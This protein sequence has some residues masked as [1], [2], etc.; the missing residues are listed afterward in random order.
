MRDATAGEQVTFDTG[1]GSMSQGWGG[2][3]EH[4]EACLAR[5]KGA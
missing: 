4:L 1:H 5:A 2:A 3:L